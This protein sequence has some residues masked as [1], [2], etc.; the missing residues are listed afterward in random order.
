MVICP[1][2]GADL[3]IAQL[4]PLPLTVSCLKESQ[5]G[6]TFLVLADPGSPRRRA[7][8]RVCVYSSTFLTVWKRNILQPVLTS[9]KK[10]QR[11]ERIW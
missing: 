5:T 7:I 10:Y 11:N 2:Q 3:H 4:M 9:N 1:E 6:F 8:K